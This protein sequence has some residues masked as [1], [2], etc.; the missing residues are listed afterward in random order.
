MAPE[1]NTLLCT[2]IFC[3]YGDLYWNMEDKELIKQFQ[4]GFK[5]TG[6]LSSDFYILDACVKRIRYAYP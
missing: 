4:K 2:E 3:D 5:Y 1:N 6:L